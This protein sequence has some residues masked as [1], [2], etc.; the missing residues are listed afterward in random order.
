MIAVVV[1]TR[2]R[3]ALL[4][5]S[6]AALGA[7]LGPDDERVVVDSA[8]VDRAA[9][10]SVARA[11]GF[12]VV[13]VERPGLSRARNAGLAATSAPVI[14]F[15]DDDCR[16]TPGWAA[17]VAAAFAAD[18]SLGFLTGGVDADRDTRLPIAVG[19]HDAA[20][21]LDAVADPTACGHGANMAFR[22]SAL[23][24][25]GGF[26]EDLGAGG[27]LRSAEDVD[28]FWRLGRAGWLSLIHI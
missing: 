27:P 22:R 26:D 19:G 12:R 24:E 10:A 14:A 7:D 17:G 11:A 25:V 5:E 8:S 4:A 9:I 21:D 18:E 28:I 6:L 13:R 3:P 20:H 2:D 16:V 23:D 1:C 15:T